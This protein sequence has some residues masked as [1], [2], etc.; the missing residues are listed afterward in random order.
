MRVVDGVIADVGRFRPA[1]SRFTKHI[2]AHG[3]AVL[4]GLHDHHLHLFS[5]AAARSSL[6][7]GPPEIDSERALIE[8]LNGAP[9]LGWLRG[10]AYH[11]SV[12]GALDRAWLDE[13]GPDRPVR[14]QHRSGRLWV[15]NSA[16]MRLLDLTEPADGRLLDQDALLRGH[17]PP[18]DVASACQALA[19]Y[20]VT[21]FTDMT[22][23]ND[24]DTAQVFRKMAPP[25]IVRLAGTLQAGFGWRKFHLHDHDLPEFPGFCEEIRQSHAM[26]IPIAVHCV[27]EVSLVFTLA[28]LRE[29]GTLPGDRIEHASV[30]PEA[31]VEQLVEAGVGVVTQPHFVAERGD[32]YIAEMPADTH[33]T[34]Y[35]C[36]SLQASGVPLAAG[37]DTPFGD[38]NPWRAMQAAVHRKTANGQTLGPA[39]RLE[40][41]AALA[42]FTGH[43]D[44]PFAPRRIRA[45]EPADLCVLDRPWSRARSD[46]AAVRVRATVAGGRLIHDSAA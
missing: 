36:A 8:T 12:A 6:V 33:A 22:P 29:V 43:V 46:L 9:G 7:C 14:I 10:V 15:L 2:D 23:S 20:G 16:A 32:T 24:A 44:A 19:E 45:G 5:Y 11:D 40:P 27:T 28:A 30:V 42:L 31:I 41:E 18:P 3:A 13:H 34:L 4:P 39:E 35:R 21:G 17:T 25:Q 26:R 37:S 1:F 38:A